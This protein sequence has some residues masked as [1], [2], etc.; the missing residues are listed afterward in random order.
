LFDI[1]KRRRQCNCVFPIAPVINRTIPSKFGTRTHGKLS[2]LRSR[3][4]AGHRFAPKPAD[5]RERNHAMDTKPWNR[6][7]WV[8]A[9]SCI[10]LIPT[11]SLGQTYST[12]DSGTTA[13]NSARF[14]AAKTFRDLHLNATEIESILPLLQD[15]R[16]AEWSMNSK[17]A[18]IEERMLTNPAGH[19]PKVSYETSLETC[20]SNFRNHR[21]G[22]WRTVGKRIG[23]DKANTLRGLVEPTEHHETVQVSEGIK[24]IDRIIVEWD[25]LIQQRVAAAAN[26]DTEK[27]NTVVAVSAVTTNTPTT[28]SETDTIVYT[29]SPPLRTEELVDLMNERLVG[30]IGGQQGPSMYGY[31]HRDLD[32]ADIKDLWDKRLGIWM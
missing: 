9:A 25:G 29:T 17:C 19:V 7:Q 10:T 12:Y 14:E 30:L 5:A 2:F 11:I 26:N 31:L 24:R 21:D 6:L 8:L 3:L 23:T 4:P 18:E 1:A 16:D 22:I 20:R 32:S 13:Y 15:L 27:K 28:F